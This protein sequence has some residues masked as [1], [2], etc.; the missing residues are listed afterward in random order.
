M[1]GQIT[2]LSI[3]IRVI[4]DQLGKGNFDDAGDLII[5]I[6]NRVAPRNIPIQFAFE[7]TD[8]NPW[9]HN[10]LVELKGVSDSE[11]NSVQQELKQL[12]LI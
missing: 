10:L 6:V 2:Q 11:L 9:F 1:A 8:S 7:T 3:P 4:E 5:E 12:G